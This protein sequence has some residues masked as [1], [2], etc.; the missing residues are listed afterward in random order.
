MKKLWMEIKEK[1]V[2]RMMRSGADP[3]LVLEGAMALL[4]D[5]DG[6]IQSDVYYTALEYVVREKFSGMSDWEVGEIAASEVA[7][8]NLEITRRRLR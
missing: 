8:A 3:D 6:K 7:L 2:R 1:T 5:R 4:A